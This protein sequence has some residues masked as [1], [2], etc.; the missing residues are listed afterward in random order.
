MVCGWG[1]SGADAVQ[2]LAEE[3]QGR[4]GQYGSGDGATA[5]APKGNL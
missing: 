5:L 2:A 1:Y 4:S 3:I